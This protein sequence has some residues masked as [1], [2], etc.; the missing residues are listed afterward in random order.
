MYLRFFFSLEHESHELHEWFVCEC[1]SCHLWNSCSKNNIQRVLAF[2]FLG[3]RIARIARMPCGLIFCSGV[4]RGLSWNLNRVQIAEYNC[5][6]VCFFS[7][8]DCTDYTV[9]YAGREFCSVD[10]LSSMWFFLGIWITWIELL[11]CQYQFVWCDW[12]CRR[13]LVRIRKELLM[14]V[15]LEVC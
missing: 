6:A 3:T 4:S 8:L 10:F 15:L 12:P 13:F 7:Q 11:T 9:C 1:Y 2:L 14:V 5:C